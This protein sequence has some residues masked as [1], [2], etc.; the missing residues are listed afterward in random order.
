M[1]SSVASRT[2]KYRRSGCLNKWSRS[3]RRK[4][5]KR[6]LTCKYLLFDDWMNRWFDEQRLQH[7]K[8]EDKARDA[9]IAQ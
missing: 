8:L 2:S 7:K 9:F 6:P 3:N 1:R 5:K 4:L